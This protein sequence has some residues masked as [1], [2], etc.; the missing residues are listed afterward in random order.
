MENPTEMNYFVAVVLS[1]FLS[2]TFLV[3]WGFYDPLMEILPRLLFGILPWRCRAPEWD[4]ILPRAFFVIAEL[5]FLTSVGAGVVYSQTG[6]HVLFGQS[7]LFVAGLIF[8]NFV[9]IGLLEDGCD[10]VFIRKVFS[11]W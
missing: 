2:A 7:A 5:L 6:V 9:R 11:P 8:R 4:W 1:V 3:R 10:E